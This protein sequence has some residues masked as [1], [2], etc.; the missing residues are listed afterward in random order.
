MHRI[1]VRAV[2]RVETFGVAFGAV[3]GGGET[4]EVWDIEGSSTRPQVNEAR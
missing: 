3:G 2:R 1:L 4:V